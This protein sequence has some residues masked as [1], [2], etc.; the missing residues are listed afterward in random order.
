[1]P[2]GNTFETPSIYGPESPCKDTDESGNKLEICGPLTEGLCYCPNLL[3]CKPPATKEAPAKKP[4]QAAVVPEDKHLE[5][6]EEACVEVSGK[7][8]NKCND[9]SECKPKKAASSECDDGVKKSGSAVAK[10]VRGKIG[11][12]AGP[13]RD[14]MDAADRQIDVSVTVLVD[15]NGYPSITDAYATAEGKERFGADKMF[16]LTLIKPDALSGLTTAKPESGEACRWFI[17]GQI[18]PEQNQ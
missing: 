17:S 2:P 11:G 10:T 16:S 12:S 4:K 7:G 6:R 18:F 8:A 5:C 9:D 3:E 1:L 14:G 13:L 15:R